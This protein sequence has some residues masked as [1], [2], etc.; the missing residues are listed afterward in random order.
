M[1]EE[2][3][4]DWS[5]LLP[6]LINVIS[7]RIPGLCDYIRF[8]AV[9]KRWH[10]LVPMSDAPQELP[11]LLEGNG[12]NHAITTHLQEKHRFFSL[13]TGETGTIC[14]KPSCQGKSFR[15]PSQ[16]HL[17]LLDAGYTNVRKRCHLFNPLTK[18]EVWVPPRPCIFDLPVHK[19]GFESWAFFDVNTN[20]WIAAER[21]T[22]HPC[23]YS[24]RMLISSR[25]GTI[26][27]LFPVSTGVK[28]A[29]IPPPPEE[30]QLDSQCVSSHLVGTDGGLRRVSM[31]SRCCS[32]TEH[33][34]YFRIYQ[35]EYEDCLSWE[36]LSSIGDRAL[37]LDVDEAFSIN[38]KSFPAA[39]SAGLVTPNSIYFLSPHDFKPYRYNIQQ[40]FV[41]RL[42]CPFTTCT[43]FLPTLRTVTIGP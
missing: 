1:C 28:L 26:A 38:T 20:E 6:E 4:R 33:C 32:N 36:E 17:L 16:G 23:C 39:T 14:V 15:G 24:T 21:R 25:R 43:W 13:F 41:Q 30:T 34:F 29:E 7:K 18:E 10:S 31:Y 42:P 3:E 40:G 5:D 12:N 8:R 37:F 2:K 22:S 19:D 27:E 35:M 9:C 11:W